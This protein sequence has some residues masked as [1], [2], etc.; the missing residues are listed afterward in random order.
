M[1]RAINSG[2]QHWGRLSLA[3]MF[4]FGSG[5]LA[6]LMEESLW[7]ASSLATHGDGRGGDP[8]S[9]PYPVTFCPN[10]SGQD[11]ACLVSREVGD[12]VLEASVW[13][14][15][16]KSVWAPAEPGTHVLGI[17]LNGPGIAGSS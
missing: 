8:R 5:V 12:Y 3:L 4:R 13:L 16:G 1:G 15:F 7:A 17:C 6:V 11:G 9:A 2:R 10:S 14:W